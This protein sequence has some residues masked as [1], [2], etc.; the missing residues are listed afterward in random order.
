MIYFYTLSH[1]TTNEIRYLGKTNNIKKRY[2][3]HINESIKSTTSH[4][5]AWT[6]SLLKQN[7]KP[8]IEILDILGKNTNWQFQEQY[9]I[10]QLKTW[11]FNLTNS[12]NGG[13]GVNIGNIPWNKGSKGLIKSNN[14][15]FEKG[16]MIGKETRFVG[17][18]IIGEAT[19]FEK[20]HNTWNKGVACS[21]ETKNKISIANKGK[22]SK[23]R[24][25][26]LQ[27]DLDGIFIKEYESVTQAEK[28]TNI[29]SI[30]RVARGKGKTAGGYVWKYKKNK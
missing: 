18:N 21:D 4:K 30:S 11:G 8:T 28:E 25:T 13:E 10:S 19:R 20:G 14:T 7:L 5:K 6:N 24:K 29:N 22:V 9:W 17:G 1:P 12:T 2:N 16:N 26:I 15:S 23:R 27:Y 3:K